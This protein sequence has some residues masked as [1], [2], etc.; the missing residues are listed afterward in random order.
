M[1][2][3]QNTCLKACHTP[4]KKCAYTRACAPMQR[5]T[6]FFAMEIIANL[7]WV[8]REHR[9]GC[10]LPLAPLLSRQNQS[11]DAVRSKNTLTHDAVA[12]AVSHKH[13]SIIR[14]S[15]GLIQFVYGS[16]SC[17]A[18]DLILHKIL[19]PPFFSR[20]FSFIKHHWCF[21]FVVLQQLLSISRIIIVI[22]NANAKKRNSLGLGVNTKYW[23]SLFR[24]SGPLRLILKRRVLELKERKKERTQPVC[25]LDFSRGLEVH[26]V[27]KLLWLTCL[28]LSTWWTY[29]WESWIALY[30]SSY[31]GSFDP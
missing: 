26:P 10:C 3:A 1:H 16:H 14:V 20:F 24:R 22:S 8:L 21:D 27:Y 31:I 25:D 7:S 11:P 23:A 12:A 29:S 19:F 13:H 4:R 15:A 18:T 28:E 17:L 9:A 5:C 6:N 30:W 2:G